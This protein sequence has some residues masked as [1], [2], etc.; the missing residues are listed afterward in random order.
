MGKANSENTPG[1]ILRPGTFAVTVFRTSKQRRPI[2]VH[3]I[4]VA[5]S[6]FLQVQ[7]FVVAAIYG[8][9]KTANVTVKF[10]VATSQFEARVDL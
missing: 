7:V 1:N 9:S 3:Q 2:R 6:W 8:L 10:F 4:V 5:H